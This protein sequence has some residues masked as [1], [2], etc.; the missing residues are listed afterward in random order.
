MKDTTG[1]SPNLAGWVVVVTGGGSGIGA[2][3]AKLFAE[4]GCDVV[5]VGRR[6]RLLEQVKSEIEQHNGRALPF[7]ADVTQRDQVTRLFSLCE[8][9]FGR[10]DVL[11]NNA[12]VLIVGSVA[13]MSEEQWDCTMNSNV[14]SV[15]L[16]SKHLLPLLKKSDGRAIVNVSSILGSTGTYGLAAYCASKGAVALLSKCMALDLARDRVRVNSVSPGM[17]STPM[18]DPTRPSSSPL[19]RVALRLPFLRGRVREWPTPW[20]QTIPLN[21]VGDP[22]DIAGAVLYL[23][24][25][26]SRWVTGTNLV[27]DGGFTAG[28]A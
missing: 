6:E 16:V 4:K 12:G 22:K 28:I 18:S 20:E 8:S 23:A 17:V 5:L 15:Y 9:K 25:P 26:E 10:V 13:E 11:V 19:A 2:A 27:I 14:K 21:R 3:T 1:S 24:S 7:V